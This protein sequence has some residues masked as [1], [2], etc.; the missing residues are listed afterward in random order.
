MREDNCMP[1]L[2]GWLNQLGLS[3]QQFGDVLLVMSELLNNALDHGVLGID[4]TLKTS[5]GG[6]EHYMIERQR[7]LDALEAGFVE[8]SMRHEAGVEPATLK[9]SM[10]DSGRGFDHGAL[11]VDEVSDDAE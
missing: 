3:E 10:R 1:A 5:T 7:K 2:L 9:I 6:F 8:V 4:S 11:R